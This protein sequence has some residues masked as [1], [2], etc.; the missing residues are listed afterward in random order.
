MCKF[1][2]REVQDVKGKHA[3]IYGKVFGGKR[4]CWVQRMIPEEMMFNLRWKVYIN[5]A[6]ERS[7]G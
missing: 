7:I 3:G 5:Q 2:K 6:G 4:Y 1:Y